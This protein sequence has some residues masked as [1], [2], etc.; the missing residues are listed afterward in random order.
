MKY[1]PCRYRVLTGFAV[2]GLLLSAVPL[3]R[4]AAVAF[5]QSAANNAQILETND[6]RIRVVTIARGLSYPWSLTFLPDGSMLVTERPGRLRIIRN[7][8]LQPE[9]IAGV[10]EV[11]AINQGGLMEVALHPNFAQNGLVYLTYSKAGPGESSATT[12]LH[13]A[14]FDGRQLVE[15]RDIF[16][17][18]AW[19]ET[20]L[21]FGSRLAFGRDGMLYMTIGERNQRE[22]AQNTNDHAGKILRLRDDGTVPPDNPF[23]GRAGYKPEIFSYGHRSP[24]GIAIHPETGQ[25][26]VSEHGPLGGDEVNIIQ[27]GRNYGWPVITYG[28][29]YNGAVITEQPVREGMEQPRYFWVPAIG[30]SGLTFYTADRF[31]AWRGHM[32][33][34]ALSHLQIQLVRLQGTSPRVMERESILTPLRQRVR[35]VRQGPDGFLYIATDSDYSRRDGTGTILRIEPAG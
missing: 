9:P 22:R 17:A 11:R 34:G 20:N 27:P 19:S 26:W 15:G 16:V 25:V 14:R 24:Q 29:E 8:V 1:S 10:P 6:H 5:A 23:V 30:I 7:G 31:P 18:D 35:D 32:F 13:R 3:I 4:D 21:H 2:A 12:A 33:V 28:R